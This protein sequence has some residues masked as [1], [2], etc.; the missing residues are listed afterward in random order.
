[1]T[2]RE[3]I[4]RCYL[5]EK[6]QFVTENFDMILEASIPV[7]KPENN[8]NAEYTYDVSFNIWYI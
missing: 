2:L 3:K 8:P 7:I 5:G 4:E 6:H 1:M